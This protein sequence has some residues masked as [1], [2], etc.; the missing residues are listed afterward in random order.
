MTLDIP[1]RLNAFIIRCVEIMNMNN[2]IYTDKVSVI[3][4]ARYAGDPVL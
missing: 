1:L 2:G 3:P 4:C